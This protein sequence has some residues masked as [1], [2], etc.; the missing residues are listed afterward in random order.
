MHASGAILGYPRGDP[1]FSGIGLEVLIPSSLR[2]PCKCGSEVVDAR[3]RLFGRYSRPH[4]V[5]VDPTRYT[6]ERRLAFVSLPFLSRALE[7]LDLVLRCFVLFVFCSGP[8]E[9]F[10]LSLM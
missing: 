8:L 10:L 1:I 6:G 2:A 9:S 5:A 4:R 7:V 3:G